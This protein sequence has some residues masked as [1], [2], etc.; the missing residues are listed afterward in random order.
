MIGT[1]YVGLVSGACFAELGHSVVCVDKD[2]SKIDKIHK[3]IMPI[4]EPGIEELVLSNIK[5]GNLSF[6]SDLKECVPNADFVFIAVGTPSSENGTADLGYVFSAAKEFSSYL[7]GYTVVVTKSTV[8]VGTGSK[9]KSILAANVKEG[10]TFD[11]ASNPEF[12]REGNAIKD[13]LS[14]DR[15]VIG[16]DSEYALAALKELYKSLSDKSVPIITMELESS[17]LTKYAA[18][19]FLA[20]K[21][22]FINEIADLCEKTGARVDNVAL[23]MGYDHR[24]GKEFL[25]AG[26][27][28]GGSCFPKDTLALVHTGVEYGARIK[29][30]E[31]VV[32]INEERKKSMSDRVIHYFDNSLENKKIAV[33]GV[34]FK[35]NTDDMRDAPSLTII[36]LLQEAGAKIQAFDPMWDREAKHCFSN[37]DWKENIDSALEGADAV[38]IITDWKCFA[39]ISLDDFKSKMKSPVIFDFRNMFDSKMMKSNAIEYFSIG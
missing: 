1:G 16:S 24:I 12:L 13:F 2:V 37:I 39:E 10:V 14:A 27:G 9:I 7:K 15:V 38:I 4:Y 28:Y 23:G 6:T 34:T 30:I 22:G 20:M 36:P 35:P 29:M 17:E 26:P 32:E 21:L 11:V 8:P 3:G 25:K 19:A 33:L 5:K 18:N 31:T